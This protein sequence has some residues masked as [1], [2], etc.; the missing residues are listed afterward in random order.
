MNFPSFLFALILI[1]AIIFSQPPIKKERDGSKEN[2]RETINYY[3]KNTDLSRGFINS[4]VRLISGDRGYEKK[5]TLRADRL[6]KRLPLFIETVFYR[7]MR[8]RLEWEFKQHLLLSPLESVK[9]LLKTNIDSAQY[10]YMLAIYFKDSMY[11]RWARHFGY[12]RIN[13]QDHEIVDWAKI[14]KIKWADPKLIEQV[15]INSLIP[16]SFRKDRMMDSS[17][18]YYKKA[19]EYDPGEFFYLADLLFYLSNFGEEKAIQQ[20]ITS[21]LNNYTGKEKAWLKEYLARSYIKQKKIKD[22]QYYD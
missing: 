13:Y 22:G 6:I 16:S 7:L 17:V 4:Y 15:T 5:D 12:S 1:P 21:K 18:F 19:M 14:K 9:P 2:D 11:E 8:V 3:R 10:Y 20:I